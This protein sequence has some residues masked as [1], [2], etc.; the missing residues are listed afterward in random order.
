[1]GLPSKHLIYGRRKSVLES[2]EFE[3]LRE[4]M[5][6]GFV[7][8]DTRVRQRFY[9]PPSADRPTPAELSSKP[10]LSLELTGMR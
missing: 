8:T 3:N 7:D 5:W 10:K 2:H 6:A 4:D 9:D 1:M